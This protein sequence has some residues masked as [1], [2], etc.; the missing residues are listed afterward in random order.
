MIR[1]SV[2]ISAILFSASLSLQS[3]TAELKEQTI[4]IS[5]TAA[6]TCLLFN[7]CV[8]VRKRQPGETACTGIVAS[9]PQERDAVR[10]AVKSGRNDNCQAQD[11]SLTYFKGG[12]RTDAEIQGHSQ[13]V[14]SAAAEA[15]AACGSGRYVLQQGW[16][17]VRWCCTNSPTCGAPAPPPA[18]TGVASTGA[19]GGAGI[20]SAGSS[21]GAGIGSTGSSS[22]GSNSGGSSGNGG[23][24]SAGSAPPV[25]MPPP[26]PPPR[27]VTLGA[28]GTAGAATGGPNS[29]AG[30][31]STGGGLLG[32]D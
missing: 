25:Y 19:S 23:G 29:G 22:T 1:S 28:G 8:A 4:Q 27:D 21:G 16:N 30:D 7:N 11:S 15:Q 9:T 3:A 20:G 31:G 17:N 10:A 24:G 5:P 32:Q 26:R 6:C 13:W 2:L 14:D 12:C 18:L